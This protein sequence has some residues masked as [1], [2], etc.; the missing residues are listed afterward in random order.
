MTNELPLPPDVER[1]LHHGG[2][3]LISASGAKGRATGAGYEGRWRGLISS[4]EEVLKGLRTRCTTSNVQ[5]AN[6]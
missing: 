3:G 4:R 5:D 1:T 2:A 6:V